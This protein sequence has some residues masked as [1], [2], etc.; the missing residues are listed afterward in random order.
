MSGSVMRTPQS[1]TA[2]IPKNHQIVARN[3]SRHRS[4][5]RQAANQARRVLPL[6][7]QEHPHDVRPRQ[8]IEAITAWA[9]QKRELGMVQV[10]KLSLA[11]H[12]AARQA[13]TD[14]ARFAARAAGQAIATWHVPTHA[15][16]VPPY[17]CK[18]LA[19]SK[20]QVARGN[21]QYPRHLPSGCPPASAML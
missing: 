13:K 11:A 19:A 17:V 8:A 1:N 6:F 4:C 16:A 5:A 12:A 14:A 2:S 20:N 10:R 9:Q 7:E 3:S 18:A 21:R 15:T